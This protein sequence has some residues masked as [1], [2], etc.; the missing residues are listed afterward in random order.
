MYVV[1][2]CSSYSVRTDKIK[3]RMPARSYKKQVVSDSGREYSSVSV[4]DEKQSVSI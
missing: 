1:K 3:G 2:D 4:Y